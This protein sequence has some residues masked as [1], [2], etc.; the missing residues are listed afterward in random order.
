MRRILLIIVAT[1]FFAACDKVLIGP[2][3]DN[4][5]TECFRIFWENYDLHYPSFIIKNI[6]WDSVK[7]TEMPL[8]KTKGLR[9]VFTDV[10]KTLKD[11]HFEVKT[12]NGLY[13]ESP[14]PWLNRP[15]NS[16]V[17]IFRYI[18]LRRIYG[19]YIEYGTYNNIGYISVRDFGLEKQYYNQAAEK[20][21]TL[22]K[23]MDGI[24]IDIRDN[25][26]GDASNGD[27]IASRFIDKK[28]LC[29]KFR[30]RNGPGHSDFGREIDHYIEPT[31]D[32][33]FTKPVA[34]LTNKRC[35]S[36]S[37][38]F[39]LSMKRIPNAFIVGDTT[40]GTITDNEMHEL[41]N[42]WLYRMPVAYILT[43]DNKIFEGKG[44][45]PD[46]PVW[47]TKR[48]SAKGRDLVFEKA[49]ELIGNKN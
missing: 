16:P 2:D 27:I 29:Y 41:P 8:I 1:L 40:S 14:L 24:V 42:G 46:Y 30:Y 21:S 36:A 3:P 48:D 17:N 49:V 34:V 22:F 7:N 18:S 13:I 6:N 39:C 23:N 19:I 32:F 9:T 5:E 33:Q 10:G 4:S 25:P 47:N 35:G 20:I 26:G 12:N 11:L 15:T 28:L 37:E 44:V 38:M 45:P 43:P 31:G